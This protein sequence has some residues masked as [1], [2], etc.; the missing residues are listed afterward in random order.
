ML[1][2]QNAYGVQAI[3]IALHLRPHCS[4]SVPNDVI[5]P[6]ARTQNNEIN[7]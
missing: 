2:E 7:Y 5:M 6:S 3:H 4:H 1:R